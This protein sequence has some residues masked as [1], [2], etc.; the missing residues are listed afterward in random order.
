LKLIHHF[1][2]GALLISV[3]GCGKSN[4]SKNRVG[5][6]GFS[7]ESCEFKYD[8]GESYSSFPEELKTTSF[9]KIYSSHHLKNIQKSSAAQTFKYMTEKGQVKVFRSTNT[10]DGCSMFSEIGRADGVFQKFWDDV[11]GDV[12]DDRSKLLGVYLPEN[13]SRLPG[14]DATIL[15]RNDTSRWTLVHEFMHHLFELESTK[16]GK[17][18]NRVISDF[19][20]LS[21]ELNSKF[22]L[23]DGQAKNYS[24]I[25]AGLQ[26][27]IDLL[28]NLLTLFD[29]LVVGSALEEMTIESELIGDYS[30]FSY[31]PKSFG[32]S[33]GY[34]ESN[35]KKGLELY[36][37]LNSPVA[38]FDRYISL[39]ATDQL[40]LSTD[41]YE[42][43]KNLINNH[44]KE[45]NSV[46][47]KSK[48]VLAL[49]RF[50]PV[51]ILMIPRFSKTQE[52]KANHKF[53]CPHTEAVTEILSNVF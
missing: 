26:Q 22:Y 20:K 41:A 38:D 7:S 2:I 16:Q 5:V 29:D 33:Q 21:G 37:L 13:Y 49:E 17:S 32:S 47:Q 4:S 24:E 10:N 27:G 35:Y 9:S 40:S 48:D 50:S 6:A 44:K 19:T 53:A 14:H 51:N 18:Q 46:F 25:K 3:V 45:M 31:M 30:K 42:A 39:A 11:V 23:N 8:E 15:V 12:E 36:E 52:T 1:L 34:I 28:A 43:A